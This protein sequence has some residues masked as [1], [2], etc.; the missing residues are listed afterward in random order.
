M[1]YAKNIPLLYIYNVLIKRVSMPIIVLYFLFHNL[2]FT[3]IGIFAAVTSFITL[4]TEIPG[5]MFA[6]VKGK[7]YSLIL[8]A[9]FGLLTML[10]FFIGDGFVMFLLAAIAYG[11]SGTFIT[12]TRAAL[13][14]DTLKKLKRTS[15]FKKYNGRLLFYSHFFNALIL[16]PIPFI[17]SINEK[18][19]FLIG[20]FFFVGA[21][22]M[23]CLMKEPRPDAKQNYLQTFKNAVKESRNPNIMVF[24][25]LIMVTASFILVAS[26]FI[27]PMLQISG[28]EIIYFGIIYALMRMLTGS[29]GFFVHRFHKLGLWFGIILLAIGIFGLS[30]GAGVIIIIAIL[31]IKFAEGYNRIYLDDKINQSIKS[32]RTTIL[33]ISNFLRSLFYGILIFIFGMVA[34]VTGVQPMFIYVLIAFLVFII[35]LLIVMKQKRL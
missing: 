14:F 2:S 28:L 5:G 9:V 30:M 21:I 35:P 11:F 29:G 12:G 25:L 15:E 13:L 19:P 18:L 22:I 10:L 3:Q 20:I 24:L 4:A 6:D 33:S 1:S 34:D 16:I 26:K 17:Y 7:K 32:S 27:Q 8:S 31:L 23:S